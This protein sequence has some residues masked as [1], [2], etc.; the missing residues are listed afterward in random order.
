MQHLVCFFEFRLSFVLVMTSIEEILELSH[1]T[2]LKCKLSVLYSIKVAIHNV[3][4]AA[5][6]FH[7]HS[8]YTLCFQ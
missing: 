3:P 7:R 1:S 5:T 2:E 4:L 8:E 6:D